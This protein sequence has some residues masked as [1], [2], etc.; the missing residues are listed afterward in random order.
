M[1]DFWCCTETRRAIVSWRHI[2]LEARIP[3]LPTAM[4]SSVCD[5]ETPEKGE[6]LFCCHDLLSSGG[7]LPIGGSHVELSNGGV[8]IPLLGTSIVWGPLVLA[9]LITLVRFHE[10]EY[11]GRQAPVD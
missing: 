10:E 6:C 3:A 2:A 9:L 5:Q 1:L 4:S 7:R 11:L 8:F